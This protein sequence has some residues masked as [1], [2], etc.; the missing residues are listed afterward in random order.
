M[1]ILELEKRGINP[2]TRIYNTVVQNRDE[3]KFSRMNINSR[4]RA[5]GIVRKYFGFKTT[6]S[7]KS[8][9]Y[10]YKTVLMKALELNVDHLYDK[11]LIQELSG[12]TV[13]NNRIDHKSSG[14]DDMVIAYL[15]ACYLLFAGKNL[16][17]Y[18]L[19]VSLVLSQFNNSESEKDREVD[20]QRTVKN[21]ILELEETINSTHN[22]IVRASLLRRLNYLKTQVNEE[23]DVTD[24]SAL[25]VDKYANSENEEYKHK[26]AIIYN[27]NVV[28]GLLNSF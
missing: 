6:S 8:R 1:V 9:S 25:S 26:N 19:E 13:R 3:D 28:N 27:T 17:F 14:H 15:L 20:L 10:L 16:K 4:G 5:D 12:L 21:K 11:I 18:G 24:E 23:V 2:F 7:E 22:E